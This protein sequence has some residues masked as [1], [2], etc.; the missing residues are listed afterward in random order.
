MDTSPFFALRAAAESHGI[1]DFHVKNEGAPVTCLS[2][3]AL[4]PG[5][6]VLQWHPSSLITGGVFRAKIELSSPSF[7]DCAFEMRVRDKGGLERKYKLSMN[8]EFSPRRFEF[9]EIA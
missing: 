2:F 5:S 6:S 3:Q 7:T 8:R 4:T 1:I 9:L